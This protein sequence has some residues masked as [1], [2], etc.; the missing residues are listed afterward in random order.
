MTRDQTT[1]S[2]SRRAGGFRCSAATHEIR[3]PIFSS[4]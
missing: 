4:R 2:L 3:A 1:S